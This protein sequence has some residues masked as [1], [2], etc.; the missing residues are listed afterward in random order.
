MAYSFKII[1]KDGSNYESV[2]IYNT[3]ESITLLTNSAVVNEEIVEVQIFK[4]GVQIEVMKKED[5][6]EE[7]KMKTKEMP[8]VEVSKDLKAKL[9]YLDT[10]DETN[11]YYN[12]LS[13][14]NK[15]FEELIKIQKELEMDYVTQALMY[16]VSTRNYE[17]KED[18]GYYTVYGIN[19]ECYFTIP[20]REVKY[21][22]E[23]FVERFD[24]YEEAEEKSQQLNKFKGDK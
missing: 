8:I 20:A 18:T 2:G 10:V 17:E 9:D 3:L 15:F 16:L 13:V 5:K 22:R 7:K 21:S 14:N 11:D 12:S 19:V 1:R 4:D 24:T 6:E 23:V